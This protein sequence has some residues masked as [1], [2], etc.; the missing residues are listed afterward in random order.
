MAQAGG[1]ATDLLGSNDIAAILGYGSD[2]SAGA[3]LTD[4]GSFDFAG[5]FGDSSTLAATGANFLFETVPSLF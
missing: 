3:N 5:I 1:T 4:P 2:A